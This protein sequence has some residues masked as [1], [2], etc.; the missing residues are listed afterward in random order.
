[1][2]QRVLAFS[3]FAYFAAVL[4]ALP[5]PAQDK[6]SAG[7]V[8]S[9]SATAKD[10]GLP[11]YPEAKPHKD[12]KDESPS[13]N[14]GLWGSTCGFRVAVLKL[15]S[16]DPPAKIAAFY[17]KPLAKYGPVL[18]CAHAAASDSSSNKSD[19][20]RLTCEDDKPDPGGLLFKS[21]SKEKQHIVAIQPN[22]T[23]S[24]IQLVY[25][26]DRSSN[27]EAM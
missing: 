15:E 26:E 10:L 5:A 1:M 13:V 24:L 16:S 4:T 20:N 7:I 9:K 23:G 14:L 18:D 3:A 19:S 25:V 21:G 17:Q 22:G 11:I 8:I 6:D 2:N 27:K 12:S